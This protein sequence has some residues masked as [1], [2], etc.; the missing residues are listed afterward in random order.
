M[1]RRIF[2]ESLQIK[3]VRCVGLLVL[4]VCISKLITLYS[5]S[6]ALSAKEPLTRI[7]Y[8]TILVGVVIVEAVIGVSAVSFPNARASHWLLG[9]FGVSLIGY[10]LVGAI[11][12]IKG[13]CKCLGQL[14][15]W[16]PWASQHEGLLSWTV[17]VIV[18]IV[19]GIAVIRAK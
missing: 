19:G 7:S 10:K 14:T 18:T 5:G 17:I 15:D 4:L 3:A 8:E 16:W 11:L 12:G 9:W 6:K 2:P 1:E 13:P